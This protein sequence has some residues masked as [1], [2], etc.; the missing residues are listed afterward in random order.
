MTDGERHLSGCNDQHGWIGGKS[1][2]AA[3]H[4]GA[5]LIR[6]ALG[7]FRR[8]RGRNIAPL[9]G[10][11]VAQARRPE[12]YAHYGVADTVDGR[13]DLIVLHMA[14]VMRRLRAL[15]IAARESAQALF[16]AFCTDMDRNLREMGVSDLAVP[17][18][19]RAMGEAFYG[20]AAAYD[21][22]LDAA[23]ET[24]LLAA[25][26][27]NVFAGLDATDAA[28]AQLAAYVRSTDAALAAQDPAAFASG[29]VRFPQPAALAG[30][31]A[32]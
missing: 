13:F 8:R 24:L 31:E 15:P 19:M 16:D 30:V 20:C 1:E 27:R 9:Y 18:R 3:K 4:D 11:I 17:K 2:W 25:L 14:L 29:S 32:G 6:M 10:A 7:I 12:F 28:H 22:A 26:A 23:D 21:Q 5:G